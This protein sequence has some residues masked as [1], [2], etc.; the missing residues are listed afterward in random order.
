MSAPGI[1]Y[2][3][4][5]NHYVAVSIAV[6]VPSLFA[7]APSR[8]SSVVSLAPMGLML[9]YLLHAAILSSMTFGIVAGP[10]M[11]FE[12]SI[13]LLVPLLAITRA[14]VRPEDIDLF[15]RALLGASLLLG[16]LALVIALRQW[17]FY[18]LHAPP[19]IM[20]ADFRSGYLRV[21][22]TANTHSLGFHLAFGILLLEYVK[23][24]GFGTAIVSL[25]WVQLLVLR[26]I[27]FGG[28]LMTDS[29]GALAGLVIGYF[30][31]WVFLVDSR[32]LRA[33]F[34]I[35]GAFSAVVAMVWL[36]TA[37]FRYLGNLDSF[38]YRQELIRTAIAFILS[39]PIFGNINYLETGQFDHLVQGQGI[40]DITNLYLL[41]GIQFGLTGIVLFFGALAAPHVML[42]A[43]PPRADRLSQSDMIAFRRLRAVVLG[44]GA[45]WFF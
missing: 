9:C 40:V 17:D 31:Y 19:I 11:F 16:A 26:L 12:L 23:A 8:P 28:L 35:V 42:I 36:V 24:R 39:N 34:I 20:F 4:S 10:R 44:S 1:G 5:A 15:V 37:D 41:V 2:L 38:S 25:S 45:G 22:G 18:K 30:V 14:I 27:L 6:L 29:R 32:F 21:E 43:R 7:S 13:V 3:L 33:A